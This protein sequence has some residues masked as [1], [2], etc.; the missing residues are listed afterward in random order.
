[1][2]KTIIYI[3]LIIFCNTNHAQISSGK[4]S[5]SETYSYN[6]NFKLKSISYDTE[7]PNII[8]ESQVTFARRYESLGVKKKFYKV[9]RSFD[10]YDNYPFFAA[11][12]NDGN[13]IIYIKNKVYFDGIEHQNVTFYIDG[14]LKKVF[15]TDEFIN[16]DSSREKC[17]MFYDNRHQV[18]EKT[19]PTLKTY[20]K[21]ITE[22]DK[23]LRHNYVFNTNDT[24]Y[25]I[26]SRKKITLFDLNKGEIIKSKIDFDSIYTKIKRFESVKSHIE[27]YKY[28]YKYVINFE[29]KAT[30]EKLSE[31][32]SN[33]SN[34]KFVASGTSTW[35]KYIHYSINLTGYIN[36]N[37]KFEIETFVS[38]EIFDK[39][40]I[41]NYILTT[42]FKTDF[43]PRE[44]DKI[45]VDNFY[46]GYRNFNDSIAEQETLREK[47]KM[48]QEYKKKLM[49][50]EIDGIYIPRNLFECMTELDKTL[51]FES[52]KQLR[53]TKDSVEFNSHLGG[54]GMWIRNNWGINGGSRLLKYFYERDFGNEILGRD[55]ISG[56][57]IDQY[58]KWLNGNKKEWE[59]WEREN[60][61][62]NK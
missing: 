34:L 40:K 47:E 3:L 25:V 51:N 48:A 54:L 7:Y 43:M 35:N 38:D 14:E 22:K 42:K 13:K 50:S 56:L 60:P 16:C 9:N 44:V 59:K 31:T 57:I 45:Y 55:E 41:K 58:I 37:G 39:E 18:Y 6:G 24:I 21:G 36:R 53:E 62:N 8:G 28:P 27:Y 46:G 10:L 12:S 33:L 32:I 19:T 20:K 26:D 1:M 61:K 4:V 52:K 2:K 49:M 23:F 29:N 17:D 11:I 5:I 15:T 30:N